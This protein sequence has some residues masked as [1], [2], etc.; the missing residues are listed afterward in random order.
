MT[1]NFQSAHDPSTFGLRDTF[2]FFIASGVLLAVFFVDSYS[3][4]FGSI[5]LTGICTSV[6]AILL[7]ASANKWRAFSSMFAGVLAYS[8]GLLIFRSIISGTAQ[9]MTP[10]ISATIPA[11]LSV[12]GL[13]LMLSSIYFEN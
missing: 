4:L 5:I 9:S 6:V 2:V 11:M 10:I 13:L 12:F 3:R 7:N 1:D 8:F